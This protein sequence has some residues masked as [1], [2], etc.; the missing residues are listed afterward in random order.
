[1]KY[2]D[3]AKI[4]SGLEQLNQEPCNVNELI[5]SLVTFFNL[6]KSLT[7]KDG[8][9]IKMHKANKDTG[10]TIIYRSEKVAPDFV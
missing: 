1:M 7:G 2:F 9:H 3:I 10:F 5:M 4:E 6:E 8:I